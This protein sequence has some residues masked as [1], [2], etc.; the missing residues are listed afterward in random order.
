MHTTNAI[1][2]RSFA[3]WKEQRLTYLRSTTSQL[4]L[5]HLIVLHIHKNVVKNMHLMQVTNN[6]VSRKSERNG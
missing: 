1:R 4:K 3:H 2:K 6:M 5:N